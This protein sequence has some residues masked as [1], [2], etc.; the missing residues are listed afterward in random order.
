M[1]TLGDM[2]IAQ[3]A[4]ERDCAAVR[5]SMGFLAHA[6][7]ERAAAAHQHFAIH[8]EHEFFWSFSGVPLVGFNPS[9]QYSS[10]RAYLTALQYC[11]MGMRYRH[12][13]R[14]H[15][16]ASSASGFR[17]L[18][19]PVATPFPEDCEPPPACCRNGPGPPDD[20]ICKFHRKTCA[21]LRH[22]VDN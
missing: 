13:A 15:A 2:Q 11:A 7:D 4:P 3:M 6:L 22:G 9:L 12:A 5:H 20:A 18:R 16:S 1:P 8:A 19:A 17:T 10:S 21:A 14:L